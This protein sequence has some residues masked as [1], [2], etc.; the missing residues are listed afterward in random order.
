MAKVTGVIAAIGGL[1]VMSGHIKGTGIIPPEDAVT[2]E[3]YQYFIS[4][5]S[6]HGVHVKEVITE[7]EA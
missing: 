5:V 7:P 2:E 6:E 1:M 3:T 4:S